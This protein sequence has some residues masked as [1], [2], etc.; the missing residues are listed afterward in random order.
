LADTELNPSMARLMSVRGRRCLA[1]CIAEAYLARNQQNPK[2]MS[3]SNM[4]FRTA[5]PPTWAAQLKGKGIGIERIHCVLRFVLIIWRQPCIPTVSAGKNVNII[6]L[7]EAATA[8]W[9]GN[10]Y[11]RRLATRPD[12]KEQIVVQIY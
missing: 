12:C 4:R 3:A 1:I 7:T 9:Y 11:N 6:T 5:R 8:I 2:A 10:R